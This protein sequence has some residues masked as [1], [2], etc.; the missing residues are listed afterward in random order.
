MPVI[1]ALTIST[2]PSFN[3]TRAIINSV[4]LP[5][6]AFNKAP[7]VEPVTTATSSVAV[8]NQIAKGTIAIADVMKTASDPHSRYLA[9]I[10]IGMKIN[11][12]REMMFLIVIYPM[13]SMTGWK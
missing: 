2:N 7:I 8:L 6:T 13:P 11:K 3:A 10:E 1:L 5:K 12:P 4:A 9:A